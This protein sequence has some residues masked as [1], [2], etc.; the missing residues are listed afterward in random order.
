[1]SRQGLG[2][3]TIGL[4][5]ATPTGGEVHHRPA[6]FRSARTPPKCTKCTESS[7]RPCALSPIGG[8]PACTFGV[9]HRPPGPRL[10]YHTHPT[11]IWWQMV[12]NGGHFGP[13]LGPPSARVGHL[14][15]AWTRACLA[16]QGKPSIP[17]GGLLP[18]AWVGASR[19]PER[20]VLAGHGYPA[21]ASRFWRICRHLFEGC[22][23]NRM[24]Q[25]Q[26]FSTP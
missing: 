10:Y 26:V 21:S 19:P 15:V 5:V 9:H 4:K 20:I 6:L 8:H 1:M 25:T 2:P 7:P 24:A 17:L 13:S 12:V 3:W 18:S 14:L 16:A 23:Q 22:A 11:T